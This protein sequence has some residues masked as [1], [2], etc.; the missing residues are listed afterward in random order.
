VSWDWEKLVKSI[1]LI[2]L[3]Q[4]PRKD[5]VTLKAS[6][7]FVHFWLDV[8]ERPIGARRPTATTARSRIHDETD[9]R[10]LLR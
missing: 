5:F 7:V 10:R 6:R 2:P 1:P 8:I 9:A 4:D 3:R